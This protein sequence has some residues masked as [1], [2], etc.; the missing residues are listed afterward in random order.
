MAAVTSD[1]KVH[2]FDLAENKV[3]CATT[4]HHR[5]R[6][7]TDQ[8][9]EFHVEQKSKQNPPLGCDVCLLWAIGLKRRKKENGR[10]CGGE[11]HRKQSVEREKRRVAVDRGRQRKGDGSEGRQEPVRNIRLYRVRE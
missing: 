9:G 6:E 11:S 1:G 7:P 10:G 4:E 8:C 2:V 3:K 5:L